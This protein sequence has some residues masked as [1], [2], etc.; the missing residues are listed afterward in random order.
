VSRGSSR[1]DDPRPCRASTTVLKSEG[2]SMPQLPEEQPA[3]MMSWFQLFGFLIAVMVIAF[4][5]VK[6]FS[7]VFGPRGGAL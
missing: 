4:A 3:T 1:A 7:L 2:F 6:V 5:V